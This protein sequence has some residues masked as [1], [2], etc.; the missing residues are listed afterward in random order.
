MCWHPDGKELWYTAN[1]ASEDA[2]LYA[3]SLD[4]KIRT[5]LHAP[6]E[7]VLQDISPSGK[8]L[9]E[10]V[11]FQIEMG[12]KRGSDER[13]R[14]FA[15][16][17]DMGSMSPDGQWVVYNL[18][19]GDDYESYVRKI[20]G[21]SPVKLGQ[22]YGAGITADGSMVAAQQSSQPHKLFLYPTGIGEP[23]VIDLGELTAAFGTFENDVT[24][25]RDGHLAAFS[26]FDKSGDIRDYLIDL[27]NGKI[28]PVTPVGTRTG[29]ISPD[30]TR[31]V[32]HEFA[33]EKYLLVD[34]ASGKTTDVPGLDKDDEVLGWNADGNA[35]NVWD[36]QLPA[37][38]SQVD[39]TSGKRQFI[40]TVEP[41]ATLGS[42][43]ARMV[44]SADAKTVAYRVRRGVY[45]IYI[46][47]GLR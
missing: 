12:V 4:G 3:V 35:V 7:L 33:A 14:D 11:R 21:E 20:D 18:V 13:S 42:M 24:F 41:L 19:E 28:R 43:Y 30:G 34:I 36:Q 15:S 1:M 45:A 39:V 9:L 17:V 46:A 37:R 44:T 26:A 47:D 27:R 16:A 29:K 2:G 10:S 23:K 25:S 5:I 22:G 8:V 38:V 40:Q 6:T 32:T 31:I